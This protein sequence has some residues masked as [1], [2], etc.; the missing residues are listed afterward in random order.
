M[1]NT[2]R[3][4]KEEDDDKEEEEE[5]DVRRHH[6]YSTESNVLRSQPLQKLFVETDSKSLKNNFR[7]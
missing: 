7:K 6:P 4:D 5:E 2:A 1:P 3:K